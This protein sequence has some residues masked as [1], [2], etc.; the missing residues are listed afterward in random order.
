MNRVLSSS[1]GAHQGA[2]SSCPVSNN[3][4]HSGFLANENNSNKRRQSNQNEKELTCS[5]VSYG[6][7]L[8][9]EKVMPLILVISPDF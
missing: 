4:Q 1:V 9:N 5:E 2:F 7:S 8:G 3:R 6:V